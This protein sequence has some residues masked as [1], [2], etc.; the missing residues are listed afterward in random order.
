[1]PRYWRTATRGDG[2]IHEDD[3][4]TH[5]L[6]Q[7]NA[8][9]DARLRAL[10][11]VVKAGPLADETKLEVEQLLAAAWPEE[12]DEGSMQPYKLL[13]RTED[14]QWEPPVLSFDIERHGGV[15]MVNT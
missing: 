12:C 15:M 9:V 11:A 13:G 10:L 8:G 5:P 1:M 2:R 14:M 6:G 3:I 7:T 4:A